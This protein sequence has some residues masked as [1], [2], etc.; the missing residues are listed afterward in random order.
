M[1]MGDKTAYRV[2]QVTLDPTPHIKREPIGTVVVPILTYW[3]SGWMIG[4]ASAPYDPVWARNYPRRSALM[5]AAGPLSNLLVVVVVAILIHIGM[6]LGVFKAPH[7]ISL[8]RVVVAL[9]DGTLAGVAVLLSILFS[10]N[11]L[12]FT[13][14]LMPLPP[15]D[16]SGIVP[17]FMS[18]KNAAAYMDFIHGNQLSFIGLFLA[19]KLFDYIFDPVHLAFINLLYPGRGYH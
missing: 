7:S 19:W 13:F 5:A 15:L 8:T 3:L 11:L 2:G 1:K 6:A 4:W 9:Q 10:L 14:N 18:E 16:G 12:L 17:F